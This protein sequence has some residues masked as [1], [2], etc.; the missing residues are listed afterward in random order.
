MMALLENRTPSMK[1]VWRT[2]AAALGLVL[3]PLAAQAAPASQAVPI[4]G[5]VTRVIDGDTLVFQPAGN[6]PLDVRLRDID[7]PESCQPWGAEAKK[8]L[9]EMALGKQA[10]LSASGRDA[11]G[12][13]L[14]LVTIDEQSLSKR[15]VEDG[16]A[17]SVRT[18]WDNG[19]LVKQE[20][21]AK[22]LS[23]GLHSQAGAIP[24]KEF[25][26]VKG[27]CPPPGVSAAAATSGAAANVAVAPAALPVPART[28]TAAAFRCDGRT[29]C[30]QLTSCAEARYFLAHCP[31]VKIDG[32]GDGI[33]C[34][35]HLCAAER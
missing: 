7:A 34:E 28:V 19:P 27:A 9:E 31:G 18:K 29:R 10:T 30:Q 14:G 33:P 35:D 26:R 21:Q 23:R 5:V 1:R 3:A 2:F 25:R 17:W 15:L 24:P 4:A 12:R 13:T 32:D 11:Y 16:H 8:A 20:R 6:P 22:A